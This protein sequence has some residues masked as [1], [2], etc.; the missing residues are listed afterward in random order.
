LWSDPGEWPLLQHI[1]ERLSSRRDHLH[2]FRSLVSA[3]HCV[4][5][6]TNTRGKCQAKLLQM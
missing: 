3:D 5:Q 4:S 2:R 6:R 1:V